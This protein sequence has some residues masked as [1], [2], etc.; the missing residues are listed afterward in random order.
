MD[1]N[2]AVAALSCLMGPKTPYS[3]N[4]LIQPFL[5]YI[6]KECKTIN[7][8]EFLGCAEFFWR[9]TSKT[10]EYD[11]ADSWPILFDFFFESLE[12][13]A[14]NSTSKLNF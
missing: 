2:M 9:Y 14:E 7:A 6:Q 11:T 3:D 5:A 12:E 1:I 13:D 8:D 10:E 4:S